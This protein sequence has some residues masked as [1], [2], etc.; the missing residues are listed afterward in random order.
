[1][2]PGM[3]PKLDASAF[4]P[5]MADDARA[6]A[7]WLAKQEPKGQWG[8]GGSLATRSKVGRVVPVDS[9][10]HKARL[11]SEYQGG[12]SFAAKE[13]EYGDYMQRNGLPS[14][15]GF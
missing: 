9:V 3:S 11:A 6:K 2:A 8:T 13:R 15:S 14:F 5:V 4:K 10:D 12:E 1:M 7:A